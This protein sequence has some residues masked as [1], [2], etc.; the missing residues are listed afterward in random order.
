[1][2][3]ELTTATEAKSIATVELK[4]FFHLFQLS[5]SNLGTPALSS[6]MMQERF[7]RGPPKHRAGKNMAVMAKHAEEDDRESIASEQDSDDDDEGS[8]YEG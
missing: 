4:R 6:T 8:E 5:S 7:G 3:L 1:M 2:S